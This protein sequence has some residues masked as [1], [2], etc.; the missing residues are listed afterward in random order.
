MNLRK[1]ECTEK[2]VAG[3][4][5][6]LDATQAEWVEK[7]AVFFFPF[8]LM[9]FQESYILMLQDTFGVPSSL[10]TEHRVTYHTSGPEASRLYAKKTIVVGNVSKYVLA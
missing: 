5:A 3:R 2:T 7:T 10:G 4:R 6:G 1:T 9:I 8:I